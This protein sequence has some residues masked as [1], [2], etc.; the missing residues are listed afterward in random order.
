MDS[1]KSEESPLSRRIATMVFGVD[2]IADCT[3]QIITCGL[4]FFLGNF[5]AYREEF[6]CWLDFYR[7]FSLVFLQ[8]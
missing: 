1:R 8:P 2:F 4:G 7:N 3:D 5:F 6:G